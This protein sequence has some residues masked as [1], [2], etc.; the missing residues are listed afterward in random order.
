MWG[1]ASV[2][3]TAPWSVVAVT[4]EASGAAWQAPVL[5]TAQWSG[6]ATA[7]KSAQQVH[8]LR[9]RTSL[10]LEEKAAALREEDFDRAKAA[11]RAESKLSE[12]AVRGEELAQLDD[13]LEVA[14]GSGAIK[15]VNADYLRGAS[16]DRFKRRQDLEN[17]DKQPSEIKIFLSPAE[18]IKALR[19]NSR[20]VGALT[21]GWCSPN[22]PDPSGAYLSA[23]SGFLQSESGKDIVAVFWDYLSL[24]QHSAHSK[25]NCRNFSW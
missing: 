17:L 5:A 3:A 11:K 9:R 24:H 19:A 13:K 23:V 12:L 1:A 15:L 6:A 25:A 18:A 16:K 4:G 2:R 10:A 8:E 20:S 22:D 21:Y 14:L 7:H